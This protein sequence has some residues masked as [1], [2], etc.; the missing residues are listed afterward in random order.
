M[1]RDWE[2]WFQTAAQPA[3][4]A[5]EEKRDRTEERIR[6]AIHASEE[7]PNSSV[8]IYVK[9]SYKTGTNVRQDAD[10]DVC[11]EWKDFLYV[12]ITRK[13]AGMGPNEL[14]YVPASA[15]NVI[16]PADFRAR[17]ER[18]LASQF[19]SSAVDTT[20]DKAID[21]E[22]GTNTLDADVIPCFRF[23]RYDSVY[24]VHEGQRIY[25]KS[26]GYIKNFPQQNYDNGVRKN[27]DTGL[28]YKK[29]VRCLKKLENEL[30]NDGSLPRE[31]PGY[32]IECLAY[33]VPDSAF[34]ATTLT[35]DVKASL[36]WIWDRTETQAKADTLVEVNGLLWLF[37]GRPERVPANARRF[38]GAAWA[39][40]HE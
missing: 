14:N 37:K 16:E 9:G 31:Y 3:S 8:R 28:R 13:T 32:L 23:N 6:Q 27:K 1:A 36:A 12:D 33:N 2:S 7:I 15:S 18:A 38:A 26:G 19:G 22:A 4:A 17:V 30:Y 24:D 40:I 10:V 25:P 35:E 21:V 39:R 34:R 29:I 5:E 20:G 11:V